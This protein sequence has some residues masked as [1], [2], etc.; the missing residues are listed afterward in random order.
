MDVLRRAVQSELRPKGLQ[1]PSTAQPEEEDVLGLFPR[2]PETSWLRVGT[3]ALWVVS[4]AAR[5]A[6]LQELV[7]IAPRR[8]QPRKGGAADGHRP[9]GHRPG[10][11]R[12]VARALVLSRPRLS[13]S[14]SDR[15]QIAPGQVCQHDELQKRGGRILWWSCRTCP[16][17]WPR[18]EGEVVEE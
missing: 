6:I 11:H 9:D 3:R 13:D 12:P 15:V 1:K 5:A 4:A 17:R 7:L 10:G 18:E 8:A 2:D 16:A 14:K